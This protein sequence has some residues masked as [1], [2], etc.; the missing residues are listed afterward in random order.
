MSAPVLQ[1]TIRGPKCPNHHCVMLKTGD[2]RIYQCPLSSALF[3]VEAEE[4]EGKVTLDKFGNPCV[5]Y[6]IKGTD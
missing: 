5:T 3:E 1:T 4:N 2:K 6:A